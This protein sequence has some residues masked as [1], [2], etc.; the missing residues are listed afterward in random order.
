MDGE[1]APDSDSPNELGVKALREAGKI[2][3]RFYI[4]ETARLYGSPSARTA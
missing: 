3:D 1:F 4:D 2:F